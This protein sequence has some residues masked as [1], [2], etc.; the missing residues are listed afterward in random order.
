LGSLVLLGTR[1]GFGW[2]FGAAMSDQNSS[3]SHQAEGSG[4]KKD[5]ALNDMLKRLGIDEDEIDDLVFEETNLPTEGIK[6]MAI[7]L[8]IG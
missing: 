6:W 7:A 5:E 1:L 4:S 8:V 3:S 2:L